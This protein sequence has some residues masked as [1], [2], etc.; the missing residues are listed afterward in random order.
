MDAVATAASRHRSRASAA[1]EIRRFQLAENEARQA[2]AIDPRDVD[3]TLYLARALLGQ[4]RYDE[5]AEAART[6]VALAPRDGYAHYLLGFALQ[7]GGRAAEAVDALHEAVNLSPDAGRYHARLAIALFDLKDREN[8]RAEIE[9]ALA[10]DPDNTIL[11]DEGS[12]VLALLGEHDRAESLARR[13]IE[14]TPNAASE[15]WRL[16]W[17]LG[18]QRR[19]IDASESARAALAIDPNHWAAW[20]ELGY[21]L[22]QL[23]RLQDAEWALR[24]TLRLRPGLPTASWNLANALWRMGELDQAESVC[25]SAVSENPNDARTQRLLRQLERSRREHHRTLAWKRIGMVAQVLVLA[26]VLAR[27]RTVVEI[28]VLV[29]LLGLL[30]YELWR[31]YVARRRPPRDEWKRP[32]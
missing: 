10:L 30:V 27:A 9:T 19:Y 17:V 20:E 15:H 25:R 3:A 11:L 26:A 22:Y 12:R 8:A 28:A 5:S 4:A 23:G 13:V 32:P 1:L 16:A 6:A 18:H 31:T 21:D 29:A 14:R 24:E 7:A 2:L